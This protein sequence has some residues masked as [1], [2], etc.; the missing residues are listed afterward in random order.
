MRLAFDVDT[1]QIGLDEMREYPELGELGQFD[2]VCAPIAITVENGFDAV[3]I[4]RTWRLM[5]TKPSACVWMGIGPRIN[6]HSSV[7]HQAQ[8]PIEPLNLAPDILIVLV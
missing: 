6:E 5:L 3:E 8:F 1:T 2:H 4:G 7:P